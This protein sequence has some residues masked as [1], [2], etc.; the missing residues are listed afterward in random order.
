MIAAT[1]KSC[2]F[3][4]FTRLSYHSQ[5]ILKTILKE[6]KY[7]EKTH[8]YLKLRVL[9]SCNNSVLTVYQL[10]NKTHLSFHLIFLFKLY[11]LG[12]FELVARSPTILR[13]I[14]SEFRL[15]YTLLIEQEKPLS[16]RPKF[17]TIALQ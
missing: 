2:Y 16:Q 1:G 5:K 8:A 15:N 14:I 7:Q 11:R 13:F 10:T 3:L 4:N 9:S 17:C 12:D 6:F